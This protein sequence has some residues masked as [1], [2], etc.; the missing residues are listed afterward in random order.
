MDSFW[1]GCVLNINRTL[2]SG[3]GRFVA[4]EPCKK[5]IFYLTKLSYSVRKQCTS[6]ATSW[7]RCWRWEGLSYSGNMTRCVNGLTCML[8]ACSCHWDVHQEHAISPEQQNY[9]SS[10]AEL[11]QHE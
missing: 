8:N 7:R 2:Q 3:S 11:G 6:L 9:E 5:S 10:Q 1:A 4:H